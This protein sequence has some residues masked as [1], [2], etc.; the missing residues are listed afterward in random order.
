MD[1]NLF[2]VDG[3]RLV[4]VLF[5]IIVLSFFVERALSLLFESRFFINRYAGKS[6]K[7]LIAFAVSVVVC[8]V[9]QFDALSILLVQEKMTIYGEVITGG[10]IAGGTKGSVKLFRELMG[11]SSNA[12]KV[13]AANELAKT[14]KVGAPK[15]EDKTVPV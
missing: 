12:E 7:E 10:V 14:V 4:E 2:H 1:P 5:T 8:Y 6:I 9:W 15:T 3:E 13:R 11:I